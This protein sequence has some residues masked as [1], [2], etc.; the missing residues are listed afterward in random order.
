MRRGRKRNIIAKGWTGKLPNSPSG[1]SY[2]KVCKGALAPYH[3]PTVRFSR[4]SQ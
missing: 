3:L 1:K 4:F 2:H